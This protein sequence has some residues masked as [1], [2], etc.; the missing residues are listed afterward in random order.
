MTTFTL[1]QQ[2]IKDCIKLGDF[3]LCR[4]LLMNDA[5]YP[6]CI[7]VPRVVGAEEIYDLPRYQQALLVSE[8][9]LLAK[10]L[11]HSFSGDKINIATLGNIVKQ[12][13]VH[14]IVRFRDD[15]TWPQ[16]IWGQHP[17]K[18]YSAE[19]IGRMTNTI[20]TALGSA[21]IPCTEGEAD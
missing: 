20:V 10:K 16:P 4:L 13:H 2:L 7:M 8:S 18:P 14:C 21:I 6:W 19:G 1:D 15:P 12:L 9:S 3:P 11:K 17:I 5:S